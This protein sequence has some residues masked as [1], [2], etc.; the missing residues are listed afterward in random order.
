M[1]EETVENQEE[2][3]VN[4]GVK[5]NAV[6]QEENAVNPEENASGNIFGYF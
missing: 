6:N 4:Q 2:N 5:E 1:V 3:A